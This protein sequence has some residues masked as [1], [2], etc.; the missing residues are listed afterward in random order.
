MECSPQRGSIASS[1]V[2]TSISR[3]EMPIWGDVFKPQGDRLAQEA[4]Q[5]RIDAIVAYLESI[6]RRK[7]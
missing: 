4:T 2:E 7:A 3:R 5:K 6:Q 1:K